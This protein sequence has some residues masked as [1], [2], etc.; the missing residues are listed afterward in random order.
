MQAWM[1]ANSTAIKDVPKIPDPCLDDCFF[2]D[3]NCCT[4]P[5]GVCNTAQEWMFANDG[6][7]KSAPVST[8][9][10]D[11]PDEKISF[12]GDRDDNKKLPCAEDC[13]HY[14]GTPETCK[15][16]Q[17]VL[18]ECKYDEYRTKSKEPIKQPE[19]MTTAKEVI[20]KLTFPEE[21]I[22]AIREY[23]LYLE[24]R[25]ETLEDMIEALLSGEEVGE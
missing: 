21:A 20:E 25:V 6:E 3:G 9:I 18:I 24:L 22:H 4:S 12:F 14:D 13:P 7:I 8:A 1:F 2:H 16:V 17:E 11:V 15:H 23:L 19:R 5:N 10:K